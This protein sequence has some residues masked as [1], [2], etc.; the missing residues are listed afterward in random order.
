VLA[1]EERELGSREQIGAGGMAKVYHVPELIV[2]EQPEQQ[3]VYKKFK[4]LCRPVPLYGMQ[5]LVK[6]IDGLEAKQREV[7]IRSLNWPVRVVVDDSP[8][9]AGV[10]LPLLGA[11]YFVDLKVSSGAVKRKAA[12]LQFLF[13]DREYCARVG[14]AF[15]DEDQRRAIC[16]SL[17]Y[18]MA[19]L[20]KADVVYGD[21]SARN[22]LFRLHPRPAALLVDCDAVRVHGAAAA[23]GRQPHSPDWE[24]PEAHHARRQR[25]STGFSI[26]NKA[27]DRY[28]LGLAILRI[29]TP[30]EGSSGATDAR[31][32]KRVL[33][34]ALYSMLEKSLDHDATRRPT[35]RDWYSAFVS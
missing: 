11:E 1:I 31:R 25:N 2:A 23:F 28:K 8:G 30:G 18:A 3:W 15:P 9:A 20:D 33:P 5:T 12:E 4:P 6:L 35:A 19:L 22:V 10:I 24:P 34:P 32:A 13:K 29:L 7:F 21:L 16:R 26:Q 14:I 27:T 17:C